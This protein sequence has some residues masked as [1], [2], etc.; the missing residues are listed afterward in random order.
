M[1]ASSLMPLR[2]LLRELPVLPSCLRLLAAS[3]QLALTPEL[4][5]ALL[6]ARLLSGQ[7]L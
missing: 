2:A 1:S 3:P 6:Q 5:P 4:L 7:H